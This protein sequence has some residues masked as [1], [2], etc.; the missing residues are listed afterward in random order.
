M[1]ASSNLMPA[2]QL[3]YTQ[4]HDFLQKR[5]LDGTLPEGSFL[6]NEFDLSREFQVSIGTI[7]KAVDLL[8]EDDLVTRQQGR[9]TTVND[10]R[11]SKSLDRVDRFR[12]GDGN[13]VPDWQMT[14]LEYS[15]IPSKAHVATRLAIQEGEAVHYIHRTRKGAGAWKICERLF[16]PVKAFN[17]AE[18]GQSE[19]QSIA[20][21][22]RQYGLLIGHID[23]RISVVK[24]S[25]P[26]AKVLDVAEDEPLL[27][28]DRVI[29]D[30]AGM[31]VEYRITLCLLRDGAYWH[32]HD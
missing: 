19:R 2:R 28:L 26:A 7:R 6:P 5:I 9:G 29:Y 15:T 20:G 24:A 8:V 14:E 4:V 13:R 10:Q 25:S 1:Q 31:P 27:K 11:W 32:S 23:E 18:L 12:T 16:I 22:I 17:V 21:F 3:L 30:K